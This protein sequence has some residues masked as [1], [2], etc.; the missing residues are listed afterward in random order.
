MHIFPLQLGDQ[1]LGFVAHL[2]EKDVEP[3]DFRIHIFSPQNV[4][5][6]KVKDFG[7]LRIHGTGWLVFMVNAGK[8]TIHGY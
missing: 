1:K 2:F 4:K 5:M 3:P 8:Y 6:K 7:T